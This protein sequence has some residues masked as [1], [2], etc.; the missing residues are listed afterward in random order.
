[1]APPRIPPQGPEEW[2]TTIAHHDAAIGSLSHR[3]TG[4]ETGLRTLQ[5]E[6]HSGFT[7]LNVQYANMNNGLSALASK[8]DAQPKINLHQ[9]VSTVLALSVLFSMVVG[10]IIWVTTNQF[11]GVVAEQR[12]F[13]AAIAGRADKIDTR[14]DKNETSIDKIRETIG[15]WMTTT[16]P[17]RSDVGQQ[18]R[19]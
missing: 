16:E 13:N 11:A 3:I 8:L 2:A 18:A 12:A 1:M 19:R 15:H 17:R 6:V 7:G 10:G 5:G 4:V 9:S 14:I